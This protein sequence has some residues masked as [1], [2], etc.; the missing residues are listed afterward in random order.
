MPTLERPDIVLL[1]PVTLPPSVKALIVSGPALMAE[2]LLVVTPVVPVKIEP[3]MPLVT[4]SEP[5][6]E[7]EPV[8]DDEMMPASVSVLDIE[9][10]PPT[11]KVV[12]RVPPE[13]TP[14]LPANKFGPDPV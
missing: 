14:T 10:V 13:L 6:N 11:S 3:R 2:R 8:F 12:L 4:S 7:L 5:E 1:L 9:A